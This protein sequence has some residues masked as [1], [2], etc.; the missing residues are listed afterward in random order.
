MLSARDRSMHM[1]VVGSTGVGKSKFLEHIVREDIRTWRKSECGLLLLD[2]H[3]A[4]YDGVMQWLARYS[5]IYD[6]P[7]IPIDLRRDDCSELRNSQYGDA[8]FYTS[9]SLR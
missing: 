5:D 4:V 7:I 1:Y 9:A 2:P 3:G 8:V 6:R